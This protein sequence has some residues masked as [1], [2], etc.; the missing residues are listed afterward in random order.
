MHMS[1]VSRSIYAHLNSKWNNDTILCSLNLNIFSTFWYVLRW[2]SI[3][4]WWFIRLI[5]NQVTKRIFLANVIGIPVVDS[6]WND[7]LTKVQ[8]SCYNT[9]VLFVQGAKKRKLLDVWVAFFDKIWNIEISKNVKHLRI[10]PSCA[11]S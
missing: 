8:S 6:F 1:L 11:I 3:S 2:I 9:N 7:D 10:Y 5:S 4:W